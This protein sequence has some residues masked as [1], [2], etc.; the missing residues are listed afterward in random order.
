MRPERLIWKKLLRN[1]YLIGRNAPLLSDI[2]DWKM[3]PPG[4]PPDLKRF[5]DYDSGVQSFR[6]CAKLRFLGKPRLDMRKFKT[7]TAM[8]LPAD[9]HI[10]H[11][12]DATIPRSLW[13]RGVSFVLANSGIIQSLINPPGG[14]RRRVFWI[15][16]RERVTRRNGSSTRARS[17]GVGWPHWPVLGSESIGEEKGQAPPKKLGTAEIPAGGRKPLASICDERKILKIDL[18]E[19]AADRLL[20]VGIRPV[21]VTKRPLLLFKRNWPRENLELVGKKSISRYS[22]MAIIF[23]VPGSRGSPGTACLIAHW[24]LSAGPEPLECSI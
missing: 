4:L 12:H 2:L 21:N 10:T 9:Y 24:H 5:L 22:R 13:E 6:Q 14:T 16:P 20:R 11:W 18:R 3:T 19:G 1:K 7:W 8:C 17:P 23:D 15:R